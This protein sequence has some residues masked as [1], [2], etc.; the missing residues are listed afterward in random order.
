M[1]LAP[2]R[3][4]ELGLTIRVE[5][6]AIEERNLALYAAVREA[7]GGHS[8]YNALKRRLV[9]FVHAAERVFSKRGATNT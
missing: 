1:A 8:D 7:G 9:S 5:A 4:R 2:T 3:L 6:D